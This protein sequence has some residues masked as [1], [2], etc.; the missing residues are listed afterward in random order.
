MMNDIAIDNINRILSNEI[1]SG[2]AV[3]GIVS[4]NYD[5]DML[6]SWRT[7][8][9]NVSKQWLNRLKYECRMDDGNRPPDIVDLNI[10]A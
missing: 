6:L 7:D 1:E 5:G 3:I 8:D 10:S 2:H 9:P 4:I